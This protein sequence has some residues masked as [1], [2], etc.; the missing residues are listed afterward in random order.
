MSPVW[1]VWMTL[2]QKQW[3]QSSGKHGNGLFWGQFTTEWWDDWL[4][5]ESTYHFWMML[6]CPTVEIYHFVASLCSP[7]VSCPWSLPCSTLSKGRFWTLAL[8]NEIFHLSS[9][10]R[11][12]LVFEEFGAGCS[13]QIL[14]RLKLGNHRKSMFHGKITDLFHDFW[15]LPEVWTKTQT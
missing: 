8:P 12:W 10:C 15:D 7:N 6:V 3:R 11:K 1:Q 4:P 14:D 5:S 9:R 13:R 2:L